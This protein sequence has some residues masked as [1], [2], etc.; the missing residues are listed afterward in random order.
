MDWTFLYGLNLFSRVVCRVVLQLELFSDSFLTSSK[1]SSTNSSSLTWS[2]PLFSLNRFSNPACL[3]L[4]CSENYV[5]LLVCSVHSKSKHLLSLH[6]ELW[7]LR[8]IH[9]DSCNDAYGLKNLFLGCLGIHVL[10]VYS[11]LL[12]EDFYLLSRLKSTKCDSH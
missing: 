3:L 5:S 2:F 7:N 11:I 6:R 4:R 9:L 10:I 1:F 12:L 8:Y